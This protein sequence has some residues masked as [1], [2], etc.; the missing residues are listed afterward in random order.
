MAEFT[1]G[2]DYTANEFSNKYT[3]DNLIYPDDLQSLEYGGNKVIFYINA[4]E[5][6]KFMTSGV[7][8]VDMTSMDVPS[9]RG[10]LLAQDMSAGG[11]ALSASAG[12]L[13]LSAGAGGMHGFQNPGTN[14]A[15][16]TNSSILS[17]IWGAIKGSVGVGAAVGVGYGAVASIA[18]SGSRKTKRLKSVIALHT[19]TAL[20]SRYNVTWSEEETASASMGAELFQ[21]KGWGG[22]KDSALSS[23]ANVALSKGPNSGMVSAATGLAANPRKEQLFKG[24]DFRTFAFNYSFAPRNESEAENVLNIIK[25]FKFHMHPEMKDTTS[26]LYLY[27]SEFDIV[28]YKGSKENLKIH[29]HTSCALTGLEINYTPNGNFTTFAN[30]M[31]TQIDVVLQFKELALLDKELIANG[32]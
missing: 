22:N 12:V 28:Y 27:P 31:P 18:G 9:I 24:V 20:N 19:P 13:A 5:D 17:S 7:A 26:F 14:S 30:G 23:V 16:G 11:A 32:L 10:P 6:S 4:L 1:M 21:A 15:G 29:R 25:M 8:T 2:G 3:V